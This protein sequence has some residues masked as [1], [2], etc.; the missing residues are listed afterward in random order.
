MSTQGFPVFE[1][2]IG[3]TFQPLLGDFLRRK[4][5]FLYQLFLVYTKNELPEAFPSLVLEEVQ[6]TS[7]LR[8]RSVLA[9]TARALRYSHVRHGA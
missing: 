2:F 9:K 5:P 6:H 4:N 8:L 1:I 7:R 3:E